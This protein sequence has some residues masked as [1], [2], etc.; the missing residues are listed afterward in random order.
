MIEN[1]AIASVHRS[2]IEVI[3]FAPSKSAVNT[4]RDFDEAR[5]FCWQ[6][7]SPVV[8]HPVTHENEAANRNNQKRHRFHG[9]H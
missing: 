4:M 1:S 9:F 7:R 3:P 8:T 5:L 2:R 6:T